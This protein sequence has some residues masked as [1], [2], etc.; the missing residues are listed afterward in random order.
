MPVESN[1]LLLLK[2]TTFALLCIVSL[3]DIRNRT[4]PNW[5]LL[6]LAIVVFTAVPFSVYHATISLIILLLG[7]VAFHYRWLGAGDSKLLAICAYGSIEHWQWLL[8][9]TALVGGGLSI[10]ILVYNHLVGLGL[11]KHSPI[12]TVP[13]AVAIAGS[14]ITTIHYI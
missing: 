8:L 5:A 14:A 11:I 12:K 7:I 4:V 10:A 6:I 1:F 3:T 9:Q 2:A 13:Y